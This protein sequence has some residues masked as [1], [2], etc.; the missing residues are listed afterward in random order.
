MLLEADWGETIGL[1][2]RRGTAAGLSAGAAQ[3]TAMGPARQQTSGHMSAPTVPSS[4][5]PACAVPRRPAGTTPATRPRPS[6]PITVL[7][8]IPASNEQVTCHTVHRDG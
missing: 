7:I 4:T 1:R 5:S 3:R 8:G 6:K 2:C